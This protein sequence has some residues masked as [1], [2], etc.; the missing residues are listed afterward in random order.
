MSKKRSFSLSFSPSRVAASICMTIILLLS[1]N[2]IAAQSTADVPITKE[3]KDQA[4]EKIL[5]EAKKDGTRSDE[6]VIGKGDILGVQV[7]GE[8]DMAAESPGGSSA[9]DSGD[10]PQADVGGVTVRIDGEISLKNVGDVEA[11]GFTL[12]QLADYLK[13]IFSTVYDDPVVTVVLK[14]SNSQRYTVMGKVAQPGVFYRD[15][16]INL[17]QV[18]ARCGGFTEWANSEI[19]LVRNNPKKNKE[20]FTGNTLKFDYDDFLEG[21]NLEKNVLIEPNDII[22]VH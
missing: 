11:V 22:I 19:T 12:T 8:G 13:V 9:S 2:G 16:P 7:Y 20:L 4:R 21:K 6:Y 3:L 10:G 17:V 5:A 1:I 14:K 18:I 15:F